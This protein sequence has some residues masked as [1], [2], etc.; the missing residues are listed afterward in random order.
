MKKNTYGRYPSIACH[1]FLYYLFGVLLFDETAFTTV[2]RIR[3][4]SLAEAG[5]KKAARVLE[6]TDQYDKLLSTTLI[7]NNIVNI[8]ATSLATVLFGKLISGPSSVTV[9]TVVMTLVVLIFGEI[10]PKN[11]A[12]QGAESYCL[13]TVSL[14]AR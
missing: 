4:K 10:T 5:N 13:S 3:M 14:C 6:L 8:V 9:S 1:S 12:K 7:G 2:N 11:L